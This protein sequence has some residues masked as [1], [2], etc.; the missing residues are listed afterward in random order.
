MASL[1][2]VPDDYEEGGVEFYYF[3]QP[4]VGI[5]QHYNS[6]TP[7]SQISIEK[8]IGEQMAADYYQ[9]GMLIGSLVFITS[10]SLNSYSLDN[11]TMTRVATSEVNK[12]TIS[13]SEDVNGWVSFKSYYPESGVNVSKKYFTFNEGKIH[14]HYHQDAIA[15][16]FYNQP[17]VE[18]QITTVLNAEPGVI[19]TFKTL[20]YEGSQAKINKHDSMGHDVEL[21]NLIAK[22]GWRVESIKTNLDQ[23]SVK[24]FIEKENKWF[25]YIKGIEYSSDTVAENLANLNFQG[26]GTLSQNPVLMLEEEEDLS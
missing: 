24:E 16:T 11:I 13:Y 1:P 9:Q 5:F 21:Y 19:K 6:T 2:S 10:K 25:N 17:L 8:T 14:Q 15:N 4:G 18:S 26:L 12:K 23:G 3:I 22:D 20:V 7:A